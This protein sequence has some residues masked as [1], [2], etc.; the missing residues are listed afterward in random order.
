MAAVDIRD[1]QGRN[2]VV[3]DASRIVSIGGAVTEILYALG[4]GERVVAV[5]I[6]SMYP[7]EALKTKPSVGY[8]RQ[9][10]P[11]GVIG[12]A[13]SLILATD[14]A[15]PKEAVSV[16]E[17]AAI[18]FVRIPDHY[19]GEGVI[20]KIRMIAKAVGVENRGACLR[21]RRRR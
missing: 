20:E 13:P 12:L 11:E 17:A 3:K 4:Q 21:A 10:S 2:V 8:F 15:G 16:L 5:D 7:P 18:P 9:L 19:N 14:G 6:S 1:A